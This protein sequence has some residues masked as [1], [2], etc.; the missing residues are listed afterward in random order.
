MPQERIHAPTAVDPHVD[1]LAL[2]Q[3]EQ[4]DNVCSC[5]RV[6]NLNW[7]GPPAGT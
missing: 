4:D 2:D 1:L 3:V 7:N 5:H 6:E